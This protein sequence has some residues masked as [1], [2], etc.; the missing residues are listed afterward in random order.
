M[1]RL[2]NLRDFGKIVL[3]Q[4]NGSVITLADV[5][6]I[7]DSV[8][9]IRRIAR[10]DGK[11]SI[12]LEIRKQSG[13][14]TVAVVDAVMA[15]LDEIRPSLPADLQIAVQRDQSVFIRKSIDDIQ[16]HLILGSLLAALVVFLF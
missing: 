12:A 13:S 5:G 8:Q 1:G 9:E 6:R 3:S 16:H 2:M 11:P 7:E 14:N 4:Q 10:V 15:K